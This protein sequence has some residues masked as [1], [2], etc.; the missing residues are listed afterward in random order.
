LRATRDAIAGLSLIAGVRPLMAQSIPLRSVPDRRSVTESKPC[1][2]RFVEV[3][4][5]GEIAIGLA[6]DP[7]LERRRCI[8]GAAPLGGKG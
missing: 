2:T 5:V 1:S 4:T 3:D 6:L 8:A 7:D